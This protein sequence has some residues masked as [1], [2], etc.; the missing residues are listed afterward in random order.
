MKTR[1]ILFTVFVLLISNIATSKGQ[2]QLEG[3]TSKDTINIFTSPDLNALTTQWANEYKTLFP[4]ITIEIKEATDFASDE[5]Q[6][7]GLAFVSESQIR[8]MNNPEI[9]KTIVGRTLVVPVLN[10]K[11]SSLNEICQNGFT[12]QSLLRT[13]ENTQNPNWA[14]LSG[15]EKETPVH[16]YIVNDASV[17]NA[18]NQFLNNNLLISNRMTVVNSDEMLEAIQKDPNSMG[19]CK[20]TQVTDFENHSLAENI[21]LLPIDKNGNG[22]IDYMESIYDNL[23]VFSRAVWI[24]KYPN[25]LTENIYLVSTKKPQTENELAFLSWVLKDGQK[26]LNANGYNDLVANERLSQLEKINE[27]VILQADVNKKYAI[28]KI[29]IWFLIG[30]GIA[31]LFIDLA[32]RQKRTHKNSEPEVAFLKSGSFDEYSLKIPR[33]LYFDKTHTWAFMKKDG[34]VRIGVDDFI[35]HVTGKLT[36][37]EMRKVGDKIK[38]G[39]R[40]LTLIRKGKQLTIYSPVS[41]VITAQNKSLITNS[42]IINTDPYEEGWIYSVEPLNWQLEIQFLSMEQ[43]YRAWLKNEFIRL[44]EFFTG[45]IDAQMPT[46]VLQDGGALKDNLLADLGPEA[47]EDFQTKFIDTAC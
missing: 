31:G 1:I 44:K 26:Y 6:N 37:I 12:A 22:K 47:W 9:L 33:G 23:Q 24:G 8:E 42:G 28:G 35:Q 11:N 38:K 29:V 21:K 20:L 32:F 36:R 25:V 14:I 34:L 40:L 16:F 46:V 3:I 10:A 30:L 43:K 7:K 4:E 39:E 15:T 19:F 5:I 2:P 17:L 41:G 27:P 13:L 45:L 18:V